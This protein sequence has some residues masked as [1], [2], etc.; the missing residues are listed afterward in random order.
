MSWI[1]W[2]EMLVGENCEVANHCVLFYFTVTYSFLTMKLLPTTLPF[3]NTTISYNLEL[4]EQNWKWFFILWIPM[5]TFISS[6]W[7][8]SCPFL[9]ALIWHKT[10]LCHQSFPLPFLNRET[11]QFCSLKKFS[12]VVLWQK[13]VESLLFFPILTC[14]TSRQE[15]QTPIALLTMWWGQKF[16]L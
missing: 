8:S 1:L 7:S 2:L 13:M 14:V 10:I 16:K 9:P 11:R 12:M 5:D 3:P 15:R 6:W 4:C